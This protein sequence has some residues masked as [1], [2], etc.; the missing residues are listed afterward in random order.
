MIC[1]EMEWNRVCKGMILNVQG[2][3]TE[4][5]EEWDRMCKGMKLYPI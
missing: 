4:C 3:G 5:I 2:N 1:K